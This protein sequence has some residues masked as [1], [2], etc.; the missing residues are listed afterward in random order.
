MQT[1]ALSAAL[2]VGPF[3]DCGTLHDTEEEARCFLVST[4]FSLLTDSQSSSLNVSTAGLLAE[5]RMQFDSVEL[6]SGGRP[7]LQGD[8]SSSSPMNELVG[9]SP[10]H[11]FVSLWLCIFCEG[12]WQECAAEERLDLKLISLVEC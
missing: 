11:P 7:S 5:L 4:S 9:V 8:P 6:Q 3:W 12:V 2:V 10:P 1:E